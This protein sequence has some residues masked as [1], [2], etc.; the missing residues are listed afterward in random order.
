M[1][2]VKTTIVKT[3]QNNSNKDATK[4]GKK[5]NIDNNKEKEKWPD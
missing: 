2:K 5:G 1:N 3:I 4:K